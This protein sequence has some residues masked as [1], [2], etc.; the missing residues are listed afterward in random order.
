MR[1]SSVIVAV[2]EVWQVRVGVDQRPVLVDVGVTSGELVVVGVVVVS[3][4]VAVLVIVEFAVMAMR[5]FVRGSQRHGDTDRGDQRRD[6]LDSGGVVAED[7]P[8]DHR[9][10]EGRSRE[11]DLAPRRTEVAGTL[12]PQRDRQAV[13]CRSDRKP[14]EDVSCGRFRT[15]PGAVRG[16]RAVGGRRI[17]AGAAAN[18]APT[19]SKPASVN[20]GSEPASSDARGA[21]AP[22]STAANK[23]RS[24]PM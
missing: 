12:H 7:G 16:A 19:Y 10:D 11:D 9:T 21:D 14:G 13:A 24:T 22:N 15:P 18:A 6:H 5:V 4:V 2:M 23:H 20:A 17:V 1:T 8:G 3:V